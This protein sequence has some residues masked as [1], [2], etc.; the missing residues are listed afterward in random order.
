M[1]SLIKGIL[2]TPRDIITG[3]E[4]LYGSLAAHAQIK[5]LL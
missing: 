1:Y 5:Q 4:G 3:K 2:E